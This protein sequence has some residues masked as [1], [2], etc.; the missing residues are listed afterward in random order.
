AKLAKR[1][2]DADPA[3]RDRRDRDEEGQRSLE[4]RGVDD[5]EGEDHHSESARREDGDPI[6]ASGLR[7]QAPNDEYAHEP[8]ENEHADAPKKMRPKPKL[9]DSPQIASGDYQPQERRGERGEKHR[10]KERP[11]PL[12]DQLAAWKE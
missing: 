3:C 10:T 1:D 9:A 4:C 2:Q 5:E 11:K 7:I 12:G 8:S 6:P